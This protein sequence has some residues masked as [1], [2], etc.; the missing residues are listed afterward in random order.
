MSLVNGMTDYHL[1]LDTS[2]RVRIYVTNVANVRSYNLV[3][4]GMQT[5][6]VGG[7][8]GL[9]EREEWLESILISP[10]ERMIIEIIAPSS[11]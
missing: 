4:S 2:E 3:F 6:F 9:S 10:A 11:P 7:D 8:I 1:F 5:K